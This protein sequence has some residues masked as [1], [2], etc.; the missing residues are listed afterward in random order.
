MNVLA[1]SFM[2]EKKE[3]NLKGRNGSFALNSLEHNS[4]TV[5]LDASSLLAP[6]SAIIIGDGTGA[7]LGGSSPVSF[8]SFQLS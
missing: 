6:A 8:Y 5:M 2:R 3:N 4:L 7:Q 1:I